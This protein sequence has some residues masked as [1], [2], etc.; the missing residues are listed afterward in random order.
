[1]SA[2][3]D[4]HPSHLITAEMLASR[5]TFGGGVAVAMAQKRKTAVD[6]LRLQLEHVRTY[7]QLQKL[8]QRADP[9]WTDA[10]VRGAYA[11]VLLTLWRTRSLTAPAGIS[12]I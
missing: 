12:K 4:G 5:S 11:N 2:A 1:L 6:R 8:L 7:R 3:S 9:D 10:N